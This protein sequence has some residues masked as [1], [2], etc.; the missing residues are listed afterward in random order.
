MIYNIMSNLL[1]NKLYSIKESYNSL[2]SITFDSIIETNY[3]MTS[4]VSQ[5]PLENGQLLTDYKINNPD[6]IQVRAVISRNG[7]I[8]RIYTAPNLIYR[9]IRQLRKWSEK[10][11]SLDIKTKA[12]YYLNYTLTSYSI[13]E[14]KDNFNLFEVDIV[15]TQIMTPWQKKAVVKRTASA[16]T[17]AI[18]LVSLGLAVKK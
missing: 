8:A 4:Q 2:S 12:N 6:E 13:N 18:G 11:I 16:T 9:A 5:V 17:V 3:N 10:M 14:N 7:N 15:F 1:K